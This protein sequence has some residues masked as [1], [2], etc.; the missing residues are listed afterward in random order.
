[1]LKKPG[2]LLNLIRCT[3]PQE[4]PLLTLIATCLFIKKFNATLKVS[5]YF[6]LTFFKFPKAAILQSSLISERL[7]LPS[8]EKEFHFTKPLPQ[9]KAITSSSVDNKLRNYQNQ[10]DGTCWAYPSYYSMGLNRFATGI[11]TARK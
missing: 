10:V 5:S 6:I 4:K 11:H 3:V 8:V 7:A 9:E 1:M 2:V